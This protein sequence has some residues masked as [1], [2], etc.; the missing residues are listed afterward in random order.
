MNKDWRALLVSTS[1]LFLVLIGHLIFG[2]SNNSIN[3]DLPTRGICAHRGAMATHPENTIAAF[4][5]AI[6]LGVHMIEFDVYRTKDS[7]LVVIHD[8]TL[9]RTTNGSGKIADFTLA[10]IKSLDAGSWKKSQFLG[11]EV[12]T[13]DEVLDIMPR[14]VWLNIHLKDSPET[15]KEIALKLHKAGRLH[16]AFLACN[17]E[18]KKVAQSVVPRLYVC[19]MERQTQLEDYVQQTVLNNA[20]FIQFYKSPIESV[21]PILPE[22]HEHKI[23]TNF[24]CTD[25][26]AT[27]NALFRLG[28]NFVLVNDPE[29]AM[30]VVAELDIQPVVPE[31]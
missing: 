13:F 2:C 19:N 4:K 30:Q 5:E 8:A 31:Y 10:E 14:N 9:D 26:P 12:P 3:P 21:G 27:I 15:G 7:A 23:R 16:Q 29:P 24:C 28:V 22:L 18:T 11:E 25:D 20:D 1:L 17:L 6:R